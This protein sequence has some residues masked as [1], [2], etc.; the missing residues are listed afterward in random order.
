[1]IEV[2][3][4]N[5][6]DPIANLADR[7]VYIVTADDD[8]EFYPEYQ[9]ATDLVFFDLN[10][11]TDNLNL[12]FDDGTGSDFNDYDSTDLLTWIYDNRNYNDDI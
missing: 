7:A 2:D 1:M 8:E 11:D 5:D 4:V 12:V 10:A 9:D 3:I 6:I